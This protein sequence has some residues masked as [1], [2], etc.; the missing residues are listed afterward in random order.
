MA[1][2]LGGASLLAKPLRLIPRRA[3]HSCA[4]WAMSA[5]T[6][7]LLALALFSLPGRAGAT[8]LE[9]EGF[10][11]TAGTTVAG[12][13]GGTGWTA[14]WTAAGAGTFMGTNTAIGLTYTDANS[15]ALQTTGGSVIVS[16][17]VAT[18]ATPNRVL[19]NNLSGGAGVVAGPGA[20]N[21]ISFLY[22]RLNFALGT[23][24]FIRQ[25]TVS[26]F[27]G[28]GERVPIGSPNTTAT[29]SNVFS[30]W[31]TGA[32]NVG[33]PFQA[34]N[35]PITS[36]STYFVLLKVVTD[37]T[38]AADTVYVWINWTNLTIEPNISTATIVQNE[39]N[40]S[41]VN[42]LRLQ[43]NNQNSSGSNAVCQVDE[44]RVGT[45]FPDVAPQVAA[46]ATP[47]SIT[48]QPANLS[49]V[50]G[51]PATFA[52]NVDGT[53]PLR[54]QWF[55]NTNT[56]LLD[57]TNASL[58]ILNSQFTNAGSYSATITNS[59]GSTNSAFATL[60]VLPP[61]APTITAQPKNFTNVVGFNA[62]FSVSVTGTAPL[63]Y[64][65]YFNGTTLLPALTNAT[66]SFTI[67]STNDAGNYSVI[68]TNSAGS[69]TSSVATLTVVPGSPAG[70]PAFPGADGAAKF[71]TGGRG[72]IVYHVT[73]LDRNVNDAAAGTL[74]YGLT[75]GNFPPGVPRT[76]VF[77]VA[78]TFWLGRFGAESNHNNGWDTASRYNLS[79]NT[80]VAGQ[81]APGPVIIMGGTTKAGA[82]NII[83]RN[84]TF[85]VGYGMRSFEDP[86]TPPVPGDFPDSY[87]YD[88]VDISGQN[89]LLDHLTT[90]YA[91]DEA[92]SC[93]ELAN[94]LTVQ[95]C[96]VSQGQNYPQLDA[97]STSTSYTG[98]SLAHLWQP[99]SNAKTSVM[100]NLYAHEKGRLPRVGTE[101]A[102][103]LIAGV[104]A[105][106]DFRN[107]VF[108]NWLGTA[109]TGATD[110]PS[111]NNFINNFYLA[112][113]GG[114][115]PV[116]GANS[117]LVTAAGG[118][119]IFSGD[120]TSTTKAYVNGNLRDTNKDGD[121]Y[122]TSSADGNFSA[123]VAQSAAYDVNIGV[124][125]TAQDA[126]TNVLRYVGSRWWTRPYV[127]TAGNTNVIS[128]NDIAAYED[129]RLI[130]ETATGTGK[131]QAWAD[132]P[133]NS[134]PNEGT[135][136]RSL[137]ALR[138][139]ITTFAA[140]FNRP[141]NWDT[142]GDGLPDA[143]EIE[144]GLNP[145]VA[146]S[147][148][149][150][151][152]D[153]Y[154]DLEEYLNELAAWPAPGVI[155]FTGNTNSRYAQIFNW[156]VN[157]QPVNIAGLG[158]VTTF[159]LW[160]PSQYDTALI[161]NRTV[162]VDAVGQ[163]AG[164]LRLTNT[165]ALNI[166]NG[167]LHIATQLEIGTGCA[168]TVNSPGT[169][170]TSNLLNSGTLRLS[171][172]AGL[173]V[174][175]SFTNTGLLDLL[176]WSGTLPPGFVN[177]GTV[178]DRSLIRVSSSQLNGANFEAVIQGYAGHNFQL[179]YRDDLVGGAW[180][181]IGA[182]VPGAGTPITLVHTGGA[183][184]QQRFYRVAV[185][186]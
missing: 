51:D 30:V 166:T 62:L 64:Q 152:N 141:A 68:V 54:Y 130:R 131:I 91:T 85:A 133:F 3:G 41:S 149:D 165:A 93:N 140:P 102:K 89:I 154:T 97:E 101:A 49:V 128:T 146:N 164:T 16:G 136:W 2:S 142:D 107:N 5:G 139:D 13:T 46:P 108:Y 73:K 75:D 119:G 57:Q 171:G 72:G 60:T 81:T 157:G 76:I 112:G 117:N 6:A 170:T 177:T 50:V 22:K 38:A 36:G 96:N 99:G 125:L 42:T 53:A 15:N 82:A 8:V 61:V 143:W 94:N 167:W 168:T 71:V 29:V 115:N 160:Q 14:A 184:G 109:G 129:E 186:P 123:I 148:G 169:L 77:D 20:T 151:D 27:E 86:P 183:T 47:P 35:Y 106:N 52:V 11:Y 175:G 147:N 100:N 134:D 59:A 37:G 34:P 124:T 103:L 90:L 4:P 33:A 55:F 21:W 28:S 118:T 48:S 126:F 79:A 95:Y 120:G 31:G 69:V 127:F 39:V 150:F 155:Q 176:T 70:L 66:A 32:H 87:V 178:L 10:N 163:H 23:L 182:A 24:P 67:T 111:A 98:H 74:R 158:T 7:L 162:I 17:T 137:L 78:G 159:S 173:T 65:W 144:H 84:V 181:N 104:G 105:I 83:V 113:P 92:I 153:G 40:L 58:T 138:A 45:A 44:I 63:R 174:S 110:Q 26:L 88:A 121:P 135:E 180:Q 116:G 9:Y 172:A 114:D 12:Q 132:D 80:T 43:A 179:Q 1:L 19:N 56:L 25:S 156:Q 18:T 145:N 161:S 185:N 122:D